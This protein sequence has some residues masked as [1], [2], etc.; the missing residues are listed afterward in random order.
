MRQVLK[1]PAPEVYAWDS[2]TQSNPVGAEYVIMEKV[3]GVPLR[4]VWKTLN[5]SQKLPIVLKLGEWCKSWLSVRFRLSGCLYYADDVDFPSQDYLYTT[6][7]GEKVYDPRFVVGPDVG[8][9]WCD[10]GQSSLQCD[11]GPCTLQIGFS[12]PILKVARGNS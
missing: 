9:E 8:R 7:M 1:T 11:R 4:Q 12:S 6:E 10:D 2:K 3:R 5:P